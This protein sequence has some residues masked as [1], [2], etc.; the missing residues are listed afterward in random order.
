MDVSLNKGLVTVKLTPGSPVT[1]EQ[2]WEAVRTSGYTPKRTRVLVRAD[3]L[4]AGAQTQLKVTGT[5]RMYELVAEPKS[6]KPL[7]DVRRQ[8]GKTIT[9]D[10][11]LIPGKDREAPAHLQVQS[12]RQ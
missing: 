10:G 9:L 8:A 6:G 12:V 3:V 11:T 5:D 1:P 2:L 7:D 4:V